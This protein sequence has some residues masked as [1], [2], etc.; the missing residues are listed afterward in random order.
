LT[1][2]PKRVKQYCTMKKRDLR[3]SEYRGHDRCTSHR[4]GNDWAAKRRTSAAPFCI[5]SLM[6]EVIP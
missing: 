1:E 5:T 3:L 4:L 2:T 6:A